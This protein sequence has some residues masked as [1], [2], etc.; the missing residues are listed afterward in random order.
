[1]NVDLVPPKSSE[2]GESHPRSVHNVFYGVTE[3]RPHVENIYSEPT[4]PIPEK[5][6]IPDHPEKGVSF[7]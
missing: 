1:M 7:A 6:P 4:P 5:E 3:E 2:I